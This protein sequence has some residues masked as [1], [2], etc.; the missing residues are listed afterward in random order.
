MKNGEWTSKHKTGVSGGAALGVRVKE[1]GGML[2]ILNQSREDC[3]RI[4][5]MER[6][7]KISMSGFCG[8]TQRDVSCHHYWDSAMTE[9]ERNEPLQERLEKIRVLSRY[10]GGSS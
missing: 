3:A 10:F 9:T 5:A 7:Y 8:L 4:N 1:R 2:A 6:D